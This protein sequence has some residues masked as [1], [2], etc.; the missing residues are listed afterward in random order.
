MSAF[1]PNFKQKDRVT[2][3]T[4]AC[5]GLS[6]AIIKGLIGYE[7][8]IAL[9]DRNLEAIKNTK[10]AL[11]KWA[12]EELKLKAED[13][14]RLECYACN[15]ADPV[16]VENAVEKVHDDFGEYALNLINTAGYCE[17]YPAEEYPASNA[18]DLVKV[19]LLGSLYIAQSFARPL[20]KNGIKG[21][22]IVMIGS[23]SGV[24]VND[25]QPQIAYNMSKA[26]VIHM[27]KSLGAEWAKYGI[28]VNTLS[29]GYIAT[30]LTKNVINGNTELYNRW[31]SMVPMH[32][33][34]DPTEFTGT[35]LYLLSNSASSY[36][37]GENV[38]VDGGYQCW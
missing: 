8:P 28:R 24:I 18:E 5:G 15:I 30:P 23:M 9:F 7:A 11:I 29:P 36:T 34:S 22:S 1:V 17:N 38:V 3:V 33:M 10:E 6:D 35:V 2:I 13:V 21:G 19:N 26:G 25:P 37:T 14:P 31:M 32:R 12:I 27:V 16:E 20:I 4:G